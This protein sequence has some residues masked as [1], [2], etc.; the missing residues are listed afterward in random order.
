MIDQKDK[1]IGVQRQEDSWQLVWRASSDSFFSP[2]KNKDKNKDWGKDNENTMRKTMT[3]DKAIGVQQSEDSWQL[4]AVVLFSKKE[5]GLDAG[6][7]AGNA[8]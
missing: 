3:K 6:G 7:P 5:Q 8:W 2:K 4:L 1:A